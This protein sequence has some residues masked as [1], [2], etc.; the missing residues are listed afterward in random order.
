MPWPVIASYL[1]ALQWCPSL[2]TIRVVTTCRCAPQPSLPSP[3][4]IASA[5]SVLRVV[6]LR[7]AQCSRGSA[8]PQSAAALRSAAACAPSAGL[9]PAQRDSRTGSSQSLMSPIFCVKI[10]VS[11]SGTI[12]P[13][14]A[15]P[16]SPP[17][18]LLP[19][20][21]E[22]F[23][24]IVVPLRAAL[25]LLQRFRPPW[26][27]PLHRSWRRR[28]RPQLTRMCRALACSGC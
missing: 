8:W 13:R 22:S 20:S 3:F 26:P 7:P 27:S 9:P 11:N 18:F 21:S 10:A 28:R 12:W 4:L 25:Q 19:G 6:L 2:G 16:S 17:V 5:V 24:A 23:L 1:P 15:Q 14:C